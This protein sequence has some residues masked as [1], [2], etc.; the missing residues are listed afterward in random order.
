[1]QDYLGETEELD[2]GHLAIREK[3][4]ELYAASSDEIGFVRKAYEFVRD[5]IAH[6]WDIRSSRITCRASEVLYYREGICYA[7][8]HL[9]ASLLRCKGVPTGFCY[10]RL[11]VGDTPDTGY[12]IHALNAVYLQA[13]G[14]W[15]RLDA[16]GNKEG[17]RAEFS[18]HEERLAFVP[19]GQYDEAD[20]RVVYKLP[21]ANT[22]RALK[23]HTDCINMYLHGLPGELA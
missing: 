14:R 9:L 19:R 1:V 21:D 2:Y 18:L 7:K 13:P 12:C 17:V 4:A 15:I 20:D 16:R 5:E 10:Q 6:S 3:A 23:N 11:T 22:I 8:S